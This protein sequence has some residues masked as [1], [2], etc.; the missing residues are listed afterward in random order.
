[1][2]SGPATGS[3]AAGPWSTA[4]SASRPRARPRPP[5][6]S[7]RSGCVRTRTCR[8]RPARPS[9]GP[10]SSRARSRTRS[11]RPR[12]EPVPTGAA[13]LVA[14]WH[15]ALADPAAYVRFLVALKERLPPDAP[16]YAPAAALPVE[17]GPARLDRVRPL[18][19]YRPGPRDGPGPLPHARGRVPGRR[20]RER[21]L[22]LPR[23]RRGR[24][25]PAQPAR[26]RPRAR[27]RPPVRPRRP[28]PGPARRPLPPR[29]GLG[30]RDAPARPAIRVRRALD[31]RDGP[32]RPCARTRPRRSAGP[33]C[34][35]LPSGCSSGT[36]PTRTDTV[37][38]L[39][40]SAR[41]PYSL[42]RSHALFA[43]AVRDRA[44]ELIVTSP[45]GI[46]PRELEPLLPGR[47]LRRP[48]DRVLG[49]GGGRRDRG[50]PRLLPRTPRLLARDRPPRGRGAPRGRG[51]RRAGR[52]RARADGRRRAGRPPTPPSP[53]STRPSTGA[54]AS[55]R[56]RSA[57]SRSTSSTAS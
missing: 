35:A 45:L 16:W 22:L 55:A 48:R 19:L 39:P 24:P 47:A 31:P 8:S 51:G 4:T 57:A 28:A 44:H 6:S 27:A 52:V 25:R 56:T 23:V 30:R 37:V 50:L 13:L 36:G 29:R 34:A 12:T 40:C 17:R 53:C 7:P 14:N 33:R 9:S 46:V 42:S 38:L 15:T 54:A 1:M 10:G 20:A 18:R 49:R 11:T 26:P 5:P 32:E 43:G 41:K 2:R 3:P 21:A